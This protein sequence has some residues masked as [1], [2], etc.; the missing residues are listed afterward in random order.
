MGLGR[1]MNLAIILGKERAFLSF[2]K[3]I[4]DAKKCIDSL[5]ID[6]KDLKLLCDYLSI[7]GNS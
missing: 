2:Q 1:K 3:H 4:T 5:P 6:A 7:K